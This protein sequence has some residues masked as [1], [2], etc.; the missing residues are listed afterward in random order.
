MTEK[1]GFIPSMN[2]VLGCRK[3]S[4]DERA[5]VKS[6]P[7][8]TTMFLRKLGLNCFRSKIIGLIGAVLKGI[9]K[10]EIT[11]CTVVLE[12]DQSRRTS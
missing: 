10:I 6:R 7:P 12:V 1:F 3:I 5:P 9:K 4:T 11:T 2:F 8:T